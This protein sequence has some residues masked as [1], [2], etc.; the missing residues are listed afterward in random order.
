MANFIGSIYSKIMFSKH[1]YGKLPFSVMIEPTNA[2]NFSCTFCPHR[3]MKRKEGYMTLEL[4]KLILARCQE[5]KISHIYLYTVGEPLLHPQ[6]LEMLQVAA[7]HKEI[8]KIEFF[9][10][11]SLLDESL[12][13]EIIKLKKCI[14]HFSFSGWDKESYEQ[15]YLGGSFEDTVG[16]IRCFNRMLCE[17][18]APDKMLV[19]NGAVDSDLA[20]KKSVDFLKNYIGLKTVQIDIHDS[21]NWPGFVS[22]KEGDESIGKGVGGG[23]SCW[24]IRDRIGIMYDGRVTACGCLDLDGELIIGDIQR[25]SIREIREGADFQKLIIRFNQKKLNGLICCNCSHKQ[26]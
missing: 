12:I 2:C 10:N 18:S 3:L 16:R 22:S 6:F 4:F 5:A 21:F 23:Y 19:I 14:V 1:R 13:K 25:Q 15:R 20:K 24:S 9:T 8:K 17:F 26:I 7:G 11:G